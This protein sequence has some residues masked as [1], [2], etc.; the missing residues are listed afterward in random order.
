M[1]ILAAGCLNPAKE[2]ALKKISEMELVDITK[3][4]EN[5]KNLECTVDL[6]SVCQD[7]DFLFS[8]DGPVF[9]AKVKIAWIICIRLLRS[10]GITDLP[11]TLLRVDQIT[12]LDAYDT[13]IENWQDIGDWAIAGMD[14]FLRAHGFIRDKRYGAVDD[15]EQSGYEV[16]DDY[17]LSMAPYD[18]TQQEE[19]VE[20]CTSLVSLNMGYVYDV[21][22]Y[23]NKWLGKIYSFVNASCE[24]DDPVRLLFQELCSRL[25]FNMY[26]YAPEITDMYVSEDDGAL[27]LRMMAFEYYETSEEISYAL[28]RPF[29]MIDVVLLERICEILGQRYPELREK[30][31]IGGD[32]CA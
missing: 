17:A 14:R 6:A 25:D 8:E 16:P 27:V 26:R 23:R 4:M 32:R 28:I 13:I 10:L 21:R 19:L 29:A 15:L 9:M 24:V 5:V 2:V 7:G 18:R 31:Q 20:M 11:D 12:D 30:M 3:F 22:C 1:L